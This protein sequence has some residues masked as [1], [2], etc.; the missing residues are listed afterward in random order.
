MSTQRPEAKRGIVGNPSIGVNGPLPNPVDTL[1]EI[2]EAGRSVESDLE[3]RPVSGGPRRG[4]GV[5][6]SPLRTLEKRHPENPE[7]FNGR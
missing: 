7:P 5:L 1:G 2:D 3:D 6:R 4:A